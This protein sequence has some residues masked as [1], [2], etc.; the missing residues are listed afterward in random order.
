ML[1]TMRGA[2]RQHVL[3]AR[4]VAHEASFLANGLLIASLSSPGLSPPNHGHGEAFGNL[5]DLI[6]GEVHMS[7]QLRLVLFEPRGRVRFSE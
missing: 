1:G 3:V 7:V 4:D 2:R 5:H 6:V